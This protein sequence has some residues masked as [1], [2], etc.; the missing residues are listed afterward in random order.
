[1]VQFEYIYEGLFMMR[2]F[3]CRCSFT[4]SRQVQQCAVPQ[5]NNLES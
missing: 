4:L 2:H 5:L 1:M 3:I